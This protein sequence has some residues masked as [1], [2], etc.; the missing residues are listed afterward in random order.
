VAFSPDGAVV[1]SGSG[2][3][4]VRLW[5]VASGCCHATFVGLTGDDWIAY[6][7]EGFFVGSPE[8][9]GKMFPAFQREFAGVQVQEG[10]DWVKPNPAKVAE[11]LRRAGGRPS[12]AAERRV[13]RR[14]T[15]AATPPKQLPGASE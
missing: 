8:A 9:A 11:A 14:T 3:G 5:D 12:P 6:T 15:L 1:A 2:D 7:P 10:A 13:S 4:T